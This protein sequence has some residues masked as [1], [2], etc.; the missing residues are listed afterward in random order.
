MELTKILLM[1]V[2]SFGASLPVSIW[3]FATIPILKRGCWER[4]KCAELNRDMDAKL[5]ASH[6]AVMASL[7]NVQNV[8][9]QAMYKKVV[10]YNVKR[11]KKI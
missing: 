9:A 6:A 3:C 7:S 11:V 2:A 5:T 10:Q 4:I 8:A 1:F